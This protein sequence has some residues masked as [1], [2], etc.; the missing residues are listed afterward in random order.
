VSGTYFC[1]RSTVMRYGEQTNTMHLKKRYCSYTRTA[2]HRSHSNVTQHGRTDFCKVAKCDGCKEAMVM[3]R[4]QTSLPN[5]KFCNEESQVGHLL[6]GLNRTP[7]LAVLPIRKTFSTI[8]F[9]QNHPQHK[10]VKC[11]HRGDTSTK[12]RLLWVI[13]HNTMA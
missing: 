7:R 5:F 6:I 2:S 12:T 11:N 4:K 9:L 3:R 10:D 8:K 1:G 13:W